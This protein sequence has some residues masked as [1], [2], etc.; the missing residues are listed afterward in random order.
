MKFCGASEQ[1]NYRN[2]LGTT[3]QA[4]SW[5]YRATSPCSTCLEGICGAFGMQGAMQN[6][7][8]FKPRCWNLSTWRALAYLFPNRKAHSHTFLQASCW[9]EFSK[10]VTWA[11]NFSILVL[12]A[13]SNFIACAWTFMVKVTKTFCRNDKENS[14]QQST[15]TDNIA[16]LIHIESLH[17]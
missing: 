15:I 8:L 11:Q 17:W 7:D 14:R 2:K 4:S 3:G 9:L 13:F 16:H 10:S 12:G 5:R 6:T 1:E